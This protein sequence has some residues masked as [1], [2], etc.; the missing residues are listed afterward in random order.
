MSRVAEL[1]DPM[2]G[3][4]GLKDPMQ[5]VAALREPLTTTGQLVPPMQDLSGQLRELRGLNPTGGLSLGLLLGLGLGM[6][7]FSTL[8]TSLGVY[9]ALRLAR[10]KET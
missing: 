8:S 3:L 6:L 7:A 1:R 4:Q 9:I 2:T 10:R 5:Q